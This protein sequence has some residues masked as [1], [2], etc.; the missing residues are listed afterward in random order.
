LGS[1]LQER[2]IFTL[3][4]TIKGAAGAGKSFIIT[5]IVSYLWRMFDDNDVVH[6]VAPIGM[7]AFNIL[8]EKRHRFAGLDW[9]NM[10]TEMTKR[11]QRKLQKK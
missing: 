6:V 9:K 2:N 5:T 4:L 11:T 3:W 1:N 7:A 10:N 8:G